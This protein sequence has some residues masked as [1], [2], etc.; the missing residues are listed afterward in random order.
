MIPMKV[1]L[2]QDLPNLGKRGDV[3]E[4]ADGYA[5]NMLFPRG[6][7][8]EATPERLR[9]WEGRKNLIKKKAAQQ[10]AQAQELAGRLEGKVFSF[11]RPS[12]D[13]GR[14]FGSVTAADLAAALGREGFSLD[15]KK[16]LLTEPIKTL[17]NHPVAVRLG[18]SIKATIVIN[19]EKDGREA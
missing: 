14:L 11:R 3:K 6:L 17:G 1:I 7:A 8:E 9:E 10:E 15:K 13:G 18:P 4:V 5:R 12:G 19:V 16:I 2:K